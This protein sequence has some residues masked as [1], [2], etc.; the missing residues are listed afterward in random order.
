MREKPRPPL[1]RL[2]FEDV[3]ETC[4]QCGSSLNGKWYNICVKRQQTNGC[5]QPECENYWKDK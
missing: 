1:D 2:L 3:A 4:N 5:I